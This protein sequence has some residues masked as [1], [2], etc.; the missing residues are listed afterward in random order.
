M[1]KNGDIKE[2]AKKDKEIIN[3]FKY[4]F[5]VKK[6]FNPKDYALNY[7]KQ[8]VFWET[9]INV[10]LIFN[11]KL[12]AKL[13]KHSLSEIGENPK[14]YN[15][16]DKSIIEEVKEDIDFNNKLKEIIKN[17]KDDNYFKTSNDII[18]ETFAFENNTDLKFAIHNAEIIVEG[19]KNQDGTWYLQV[20][21]LDRFD[22]TDFVFPEE[23]DNKYQEINKNENKSTTEKTISSVKNGLGYTLNNMALA[24]VQYG[25]LKEYDLKINFDIENYKEEGD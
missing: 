17:Y 6:I 18:K 11:Y 2:N 22:F 19:N 7:Y 3:Y 21:I 12:A 16:T 25:V 1:F 5:N 15:I 8:Y 24:S 9:A 10:G 14:K 20:E 23:Y 13:L 4:I